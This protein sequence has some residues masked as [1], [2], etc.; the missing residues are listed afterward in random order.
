MMPTNYRENVYRNVKEIGNNNKQHFQTTHTHV[1]VYPIP[2]PSF[3]LEVIFFSYW[4][5]IGI[6]NDNGNG[7]HVNEA[8]DKHCNLQHALLITFRVLYVLDLEGDGTNYH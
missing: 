1:A 6:A 4:K 5:C 3:H 8:K 7:L 2:F